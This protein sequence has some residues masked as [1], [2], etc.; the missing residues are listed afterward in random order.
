M[1]TGTIVTN[2]PDVGPAA[3]FWAKALGYKPREGPDEGWAM[4]VP[5]GGN[6][7]NMAFDRSDRTHL[8]LYAANAAEQ[9]A[10]V[11]RLIWARREAGRGLAVSRGRRI[12][13]AR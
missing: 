12:R 1:V 11:E 10:E 5:D 3:E 13:R 2:T 9:R 4:N 7:P 6:G 8:D